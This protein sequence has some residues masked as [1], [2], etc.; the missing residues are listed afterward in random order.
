MTERRSLSLKK[1]FR[2]GNTNR[3]ITL[4]MEK[5]TKGDQNNVGQPS[6]LQ[7][8]LEAAKKSKASKTSY[9]EVLQ[10]YETV[11][12][13]YNSLTIHQEFGADPPFLSRP[14]F[15]LFLRG[16]QTHVDQVHAVLTE[17]LD[18]CWEGTLATF[19]EKMKD[20][21]EVEE[22]RLLQAIEAIATTKGEKSDDYE[23]ATDELAKT[24]QH[25]EAVEEKLRDRLANPEKHAKSNER[26]DC[27]GCCCRSPPPPPRHHSHHKREEYNPRKSNRGSKGGYGRGG[28]YHPYRRH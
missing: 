14:K 23:A 10:S 11:T 3:T 26:E 7:Q 20:Q 16:N 5:K 6:K 17:T 2:F 9:T 4:N 19:T 18:T 28:K 15:N 1:T 24:N 21:K 25:L 13:A 8:I 22:S 27:N 12:T